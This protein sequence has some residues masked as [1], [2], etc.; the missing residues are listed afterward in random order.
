MTGII[1]TILYWF[2]ISIGVGIVWG[3]YCLAADW[4]RQLDADPTLTA[5]RRGEDD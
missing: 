2:S 3:I 5:L 1:L 4:K